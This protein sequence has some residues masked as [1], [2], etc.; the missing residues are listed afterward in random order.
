M[1]QEIRRAPGRWGGTDFLDGWRGIAAV[2]VAVGHARYLVAA[3]YH[4]GL[5]AH[6]GDYSEVGRLAFWLFTPFRFGYQWVLFFFILSGFVI[7]LR[8]AEKLHGES[9]GPRLRGSSVKF[10]WRQFV[11][12]RFRRLYPPLLLAIA[13]TYLLD[14]AGTTP[15]VPGYYGSAAMQASLAH[16]RPVHTLGTLLGNLTFT[17]RCYTHCW[18][19]DGPLWSLHFEWWFYMFYPLFFWLCRKKMGLD[20]LAIAVLFALSFLPHPFWARLPFQIFQAM[21]IWWL[22]ALLAEVYVG[23]IRLGMGWLAPLVFLLPLMAAISALN[24]LRL[25]PGKL[26]GVAGGV[27]WTL[28]FIGLLAA[29]FWWQGRG[30]RLTPLLKLKWVGEMSYTLYVTH[31]PIILFLGGWL[32]WYTH[33]RAP[34]R[35][36]VFVLPAVAVAFGFA[37]LAHFLVERPFLAVARKAPLPRPVAAAVKAEASG[38]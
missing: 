38:G 28:G 26:P 21:V 12:R 3:N 24:K 6:P 11:W 36:E 35:T 13:V 5:S 33:G 19:S 16:F 29:C 17:M 27:L 31:F 37:Y 14:K 23:R 15:G 30:R 8:Y 32:L 7:H 22:G 1:V 25:L 2:M 4:E 18:G 20:S 10:G 9:L 34:P